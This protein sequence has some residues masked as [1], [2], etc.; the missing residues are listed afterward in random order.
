MNQ[1]ALWIAIGATIA[2]C[3]FAACSAALRSFSRSKLSDLLEESDKSQKLEPFLERTSA[4]VLITSTMRVGLN[5]VVL[6]CILSLF[7]SVFGAGEQQ[8]L[9]YMVSFAVA[10]LVIS[11]FAVAIP[12]SM[13]RYQAERLLVRTMPLLNISVAVFRPLASLLY[14]F[15]PIV[16]RISGDQTSLSS[17]DELLTEEI[18]SVV[19][20][21][22]EDAAVDEDQ[23]DMLEG[24]IE[25]R[26]TTAGQIM[27]PRTDVKGIE[28]DASLEQVKDAIITLGHSR[29]PVFRDNLD[30]IVGMLYAKDMIKFL[31]QN[32]QPFDLKQVIR[33]A[34]MVPESKA[35]GELLGEFKARK[36]HIA[37]VLDEYGGTAGLVTI[38]DILE[39]IVGEIHDEYE[40]V[41]DNP[42]IRKLDDRVAEVDA[43]VYVDDLNDE[44]RLKLPEDDGYDTVG[45]FVFSTLGHI[46]AVDESFEFDN[47]R[48][49]VTDAERTR[50][51]Q[52][53]VEVLAASSGDDG[54]ER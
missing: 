20:D 41:K 28:S 54:N 16:R 6:L 15:D 5:L 35:V 37:V 33:D 34:F 3:Y 25:L 38:E 29:I 32:G 14:L 30:G 36:I 7:E 26:S 18:L 1:V 21:H 53:R 13:A 9:K 50:V 43:R 52:I 19:E 39:E 8:L 42:S 31:G 51:N 47:I 11:V 24:V 45:G 12:V 49:T 48:I 17:S 22:E 46:P 44:M 40:P 27:T 4:L 23:K 2:G 10:A